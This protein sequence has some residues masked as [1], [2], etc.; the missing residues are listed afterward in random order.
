MEYHVWSLYSSA[1]WKAKIVHNFGLSECNRVQVNE[2]IFREN[3]SFISIW[4]PFYK[5]GQPYGKN[6]LPWEQILLFSS[7][8]YL[9]RASFQ[10]AIRKLHK[11]FPL[12]QWQKHI[13]LYLFTLKWLSHNFFQDIKP[14]PVTDDSDDLHMEGYLFK[15]TKHAFKT[16]VRYVNKHKWFTPGRVPL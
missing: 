6:L 7:R 16:W 10:E 5:W 3:N 11:L 4:P 14:G 13:F 12:K 9:G 8:P 15:R 2:H 1:V